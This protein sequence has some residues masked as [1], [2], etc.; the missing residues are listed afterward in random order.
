[1]GAMKSAAGKSGPA[2]VGTERPARYTGQSQQSGPG[3]LWWGQADPATFQRCVDQVN[4]V[5]DAIS[6]ARGARG[7]WVSVTILSGGE[8]FK[9]VATTIE[10]MDA[11]LDE[12][13]NEATKS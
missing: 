5:G 10:E 2:R 8:R 4:A 9:K 11:L 3:G 1:M 12:T 7:A 6:F 13:W